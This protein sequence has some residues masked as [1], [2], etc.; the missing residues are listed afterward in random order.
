MKQPYELSIAL[1]Y[2]R[3]R[4]RKSFISFISLVSMIGIGLAVAVLIVVLSVMN[5]FEHTLQQKILGIASHAT[6]NGYDGPLEDWQ[7]LRR[8][9]LA[10]S[11]VAAAAPFVEEQALAAADVATAPVNVRGVEPALEKTVSSI[12]DVLTSGS[13][14]AL[15]PGAYRMIIGT[16][17]A[18]ELGVG[19]GDKIVLAVAQAS[20]SP[21]GIL[22]RLRTFTVAGVFNAGMYE[23]DRGLALV[24]MEDA[25]RLFGTQGKATGLRLAVRD[26]YAANRIAVELARGLRQRTYVTDWTREHA[27]FF[28]SI[29]LTRSIMFVILSMVIA[30]AAFNIVSTLVMVVR[31]KRGD[32]AILRSFGA[33]PRSILAVF[34]SQGTLIGIV[35]TALGVALG[36]LVTSELDAIV[37]LIER[38]FH[39]DLLAAQVYFLSE[40]PTQVRPGELAKI[41]LLA[42]A[43]AVLAT[44][45]PAFS[46]ARQPPAEALRYE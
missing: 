40:L 10:R 2:L 46:A 32:I 18:A 19:V 30:V 35:G 28:A 13:L 41:C 8:R 36:L 26:V 12:E 34:A 4:R 23:Y 6:I 11:D 21:V 33:A 1:R 39:V 17:L 9:A 27:N 22:P 37:A 44:L 38:T 3:A 7:D 25:E 31:D 29:R 24:N 14:S 43:L 16:A 15:E 42:L 5:G 20:I 45:Y